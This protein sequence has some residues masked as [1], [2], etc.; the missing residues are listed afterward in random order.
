MPRRSTETTGW[1]LSTSMPDRDSHTG[2]CTEVGRSEPVVMTS[3]PASAGVSLDRARTTPMLTVPLAP[4][5]GS[6]SAS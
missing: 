5:M 6:R 1:L 4:A 3:G 2:N